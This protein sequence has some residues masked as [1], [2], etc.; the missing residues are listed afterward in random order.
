MSIAQTAWI[1]AMR[2]NS[3]RAKGEETLTR[4]PSPSV[5]STCVVDQKRATSS[6]RDLR[7]FPVRVQARALPTSRTA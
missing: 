6:D 2:W 4:I 3:C 7:A 1:F 5:N